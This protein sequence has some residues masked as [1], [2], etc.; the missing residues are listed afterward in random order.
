VVFNKVKVSGKNIVG[1][2][3]QAWGPLEKTLQQ[4]TVARCAEMVGE[5]KKY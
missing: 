5:L 2:L 3:E 1:K 4:V